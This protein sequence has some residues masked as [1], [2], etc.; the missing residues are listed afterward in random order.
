MLARSTKIC[1][2]LIAE[3]FWLLCT[4]FFRNLVRFFLIVKFV[5]LPEI[6]LEAD[7]GLKRLANIS[8]FL[9]LLTNLTMIGRCSFPSAS[10][11]FKFILGVLGLGV[12]LE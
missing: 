11:Y 7:L 9:S 5:F 4:A 8:F 1:I 12:W 6:E 3:L 2:Q 10:V